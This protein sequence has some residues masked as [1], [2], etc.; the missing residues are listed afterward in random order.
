MEEDKEE[1]WKTRKMALILLAGSNAVARRGT[2]LDLLVSAVSWHRECRKCEPWRQMR[3]KCIDACVCVHA[4]ACVALGA[5]RSVRWEAEGWRKQGW[6][7][8]DC[9][10]EG[11]GLRCSGGGM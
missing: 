4:R 7:G 6:G 11:L 10:R 2:E 9:W 5:L 1:V 8:Q 3:R